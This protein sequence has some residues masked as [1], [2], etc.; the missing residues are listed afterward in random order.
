MRPSVSVSLLDK[1]S[2]DALLTIGARGTMLTYGPLGRRIIMAVDN[3]GD[4]DCTYR[5][6]YAPRR[7]SE[8][9]G[10]DS[11]PSARNKRNANQSWG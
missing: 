2:G 9:A 8:Q 4:W 6:D 3:C 11:L 1:I 5:D 10:R 7:G